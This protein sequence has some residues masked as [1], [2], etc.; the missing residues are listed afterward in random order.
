M[1][2]DTARDQSLLTSP[3]NYK[4]KNNILSGW[5]EFVLIL[6]KIISLDADFIFKLFQISAKMHTLK[7]WEKYFYV[8]IK[9]FLF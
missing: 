2:N 4:S 8:V 9:M 1:H 3:R 6:F 5:L 7:F